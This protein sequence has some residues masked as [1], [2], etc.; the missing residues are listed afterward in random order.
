MRLDGCRIVLTGASGGIGRHLALQLAV[1]GA[2]LALVGRRGVALA[3]VCGGLPGGERASFTVVADVTQPSG[4][5]AVVAAA[6]ERMGGVDL[7]VNNAG[8]LEFGAFTAAAPAAIETLYQ[9]NLVAPILLTRALLPGMIAAGR[10]HLTFVGSILGSLALPFHAN[11]AASKFGLRGFTEALRR[12]LAGSG[13]TVTYVA[14]RATRTGL[15]SDAVY[16]MGE[17]TGMH[18]DEPEAVATAIVRAI[19]GRRREV[20]LGRPEGFFARLNTMWP[21]LM[22]VALRKQ[23][24]VMREFAIDAAGERR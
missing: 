19:V 13:V 23:T 12:E 17:A 16:R 15:N 14:P 8:I 4:R 11:Y 10:G 24:R 21:G 7:L 18:V 3:E 9:T 22:D 20:F 1:A 6:S 5:Q 2:R